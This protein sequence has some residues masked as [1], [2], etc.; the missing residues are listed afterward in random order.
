MKRSLALFAALIVVSLSGLIVT[1]GVV[2]GSAEN[3][4]V[5]EDII[6]GDASF[7][8]GL[9]VHGVSRYGY[10]LYWDSEMKFENSVRTDSTDFRYY[11]LNRGDPRRG[12]S[13]PKV[14]YSDE[15]GLSMPVVYNF[16][17]N[18]KFAKDV[19]KWTAEL[20]P[21]SQEKRTVR[22]ADYYKYYP[23][24][25]NLALPG[26][27]YSG[28]ALPYTT[29]WDDFQTK[30][31]RYFRIPVLDDEYLEI[32]LTKSENSFLYPSQSYSS[33]SHASYGHE[34]TPYCNGVYT[35]DAYYFYFANR[36]ERRIEAGFLTT[37]DDEILV[38]TSRIPGGYGVYRIPCVESERGAL[39]DIDGLSTA[40]PIDE[41]AQITSLGASPDR[42]KLFLHTIEDRTWYLSV[43]DRESM[44]LLQKIEIRRNMPYFPPSLDGGAF[45]V[46][47][48]NFLLVNF[49]DPTPE[50]VVLD[51][52]E[53]GYAVRQRIVNDGTPADNARA[54]DW[55]DSQMLDAA[56]AW[57]GERLAVVWNPQK[58]IN[59]NR[60]TYEM[61]GV[62]VAVC[63]NNSLQFFA[64]YGNSLDECN[65]R[66]SSAD[67]RSIRFSAYSFPY[68][69]F[70][71]PEGNAARAYWS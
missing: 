1:C 28:Q 65:L 55:W 43:I 53:D 10:Y 41:R 46:N 7:A 58:M 49:R 35:G 33:Y 9:T 62:A 67:E 14:S 5:T 64:E 13:D 54:W 26:A 30:F 37:P 32:T 36:A 60:W 21:Q 42:S 3:V 66:L 6:Y 63:A 61:C 2:G 47:G 25:P 38:D 4:A 29:S 40:Y 52:R 15:T 27:R 48:D 24:Y 71:R 34:F 16:Y 56:Y 31:Q 39:A 20:E 12:R 23:V 50:I 19:E 70:V 22:V 69:S 68:A 57:D 18:D 45:V 59:D 8:D 51:E 11:Q 44:A 17:P